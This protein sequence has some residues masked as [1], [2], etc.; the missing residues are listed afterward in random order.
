MGINPRWDI[1]DT[2][3]RT[4]VDWCIHGKY[5]AVFEARFSRR[6]MD[7]DFW[8]S[9]QFGKKQLWSDWPRLGFAKNATFFWQFVAI[10]QWDI[11]FW[12]SPYH[13]SFFLQDSRQ[14]GSEGENSRR[15]RKKNL[16]NWVTKIECD[17]L[18]TFSLPRKFENWG[19]WPLKSNPS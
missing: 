16:R 18:S 3:P 19:R 8:I 4:T 5:D 11:Y 1:F 14:L 9:G 15:G 13:L 7:F 6:S 10:P 2:K 12:R 17:G